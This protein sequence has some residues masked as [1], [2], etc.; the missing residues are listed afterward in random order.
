MKLAI[1]GPEFFSYTK[2]ISNELAGRGIDVIFFDERGEAGAVKK[3]IFRSTILQKVFNQYI[4]RAHEV[5]Y[6]KLISN[7]ITHVLFISP[8]SLNISLI[9][10][11]KNSGISISLYMWD[12]VDNKPSVKYVF[13]YIEN[14]ATFDPADSKKYSIEYI[15]LFAEDVYFNKQVEITDREYD[16]CFI[17]T[18]HSNRASQLKSVLKNKSFS[19]FRFKIHLFYGNYLYDIMSRL[20]LIGFSELKPTDKKLS[21]IECADIFSKSKYVLDITH[22]KQRGLTSRTFEALCSGAILVTNNINAPTLI[23]SFNKNIVLYDDLSS[24]NIEQLKQSSSPSDNVDRYPLSLSYFCSNILE[25][26]NK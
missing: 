17:G 3:T 14:K 2:A 12:S 24:I 1:V 26:I 11:I 6:E 5:I 19:D 15:H 7:N 18:G 20:Q 16:L 25:L 13:D 23:P 22:P 8:D 21:K 4:T 9:K 10:K